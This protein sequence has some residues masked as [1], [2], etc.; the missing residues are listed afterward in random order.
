MR[1]IRN[2]EDSIRGVP[3]SNWKGLRLVCI[4]TA[5]GG[6]FELKCNIYRREVCN[7][8][9][10]DCH[11]VWLGYYRYWE[12]PPS[13]SFTSWALFQHIEKRLST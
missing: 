1:V 6:L 7:G 2:S 12:V 8:R 3:S 4:E 10:E 9:Y 11:V 5:T 13:Y